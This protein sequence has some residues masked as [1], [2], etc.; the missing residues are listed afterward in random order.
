MISPGH[1]HLAEEIAM[2]LVQCIECGREVPP[3]G[4]C[5]YCGAEQDERKAGFR[6]RRQQGGADRRRVCPECRGRRRCLDCAG[7]GKTRKA[8]GGLLHFLVRLLRPRSAYQEIACPS[9]GGSRKCAMCGG[10]G[11]IMA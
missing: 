6:V 3:A 7:T 11:S 4:I 2:G 5:P 9:C 1:P 8:Q 10:F